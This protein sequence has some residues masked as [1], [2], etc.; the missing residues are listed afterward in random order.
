MRARV[1]RCTLEQQ[2]CGDGGSSGAAL[3]LC[4]PDVAHRVCAPHPSTCTHS[5]THTRTP[6]SRP[7]HPLM[8]PSTRPIAVLVPLPRSNCSARALPPSSFPTRGPV[9]ARVHAAVHDIGVRHEAHWGVWRPAAAAGR[10]GHPVPAAVPARHGWRGRRADARGGTHVRWRA[11]APACVP[12]SHPLLCLP[13][14]SVSGCGL[15]RCGGVRRFAKFVS[16]EVPRLELLL[17]LVSTPKERFSDRCRA[18]GGCCR[19]GGAIWRVAVRRWRAGDWGLWGACPPPPGRGQSRFRAH[20]QMAT[21]TAM[22]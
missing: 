22:R 16:R 1:P 9:C 3:I 8:F 7:S 18:V 17:K 6:P 21:R 19:G 4:E 15:R 13:G 11:R 14:V 20:V 10:G 2:E 5:L 12:L